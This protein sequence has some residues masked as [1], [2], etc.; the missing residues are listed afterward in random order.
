MI[1]RLVSLKAL[2]EALPTNFRSESHWNI[3]VFRAALRA[4]VEA[5]A[6]KKKE[7][8]DGYKAAGELRRRTCSIQHSGCR[9]PVRPA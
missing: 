9:T 2:A 6:T 1:A 5:A 8:P 4:A 3:R 7:D